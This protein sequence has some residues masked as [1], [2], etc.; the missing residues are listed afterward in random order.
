[1]QPLQAKPS[2]LPTFNQLTTGGVLAY[3]VDAYIYDTPSTLKPPFYAPYN[4]PCRPNAPIAGVSPQVRNS[5]TAPRVQKTDKFLNTAGKAAL[6]TTAAV[7]TG[8]VLK[9]KFPDSVLTKALQR[10]GDYLKTLP[11]KI[12]AFFKSAP[13]P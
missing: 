8:A 11:S 9:K 5:P 3:D 7:T 1:M 4:M 10:A 6:G 13:K 2:Y 12:A